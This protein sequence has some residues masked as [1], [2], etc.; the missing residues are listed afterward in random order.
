MV[1]WE[2]ASWSQLVLSRYIFVVTM[3]VSFTELYSH[4][5]KVDFSEIYYDFPVLCEPNE[6]ER[7]FSSCLVLFCLLSTNYPKPYTC[8]SLWAT[9]LVFQAEYV[10]V[11]WIKDFKIEYRSYNHLLIWNKRYHMATSFKPTCLLRH[12]NV[13]ITQWSWHLSTSKLILNFLQ[14][15]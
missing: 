7:H 9:I 2:G 12:K 6:Q 15:L 4:Q 5:I 14:L 8:L 10:S 1:Q 13:K 3:V 11:S